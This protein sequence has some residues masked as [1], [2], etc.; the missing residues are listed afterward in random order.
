M[1]RISTAFNRQ[2]KK[3]EDDGIDN[4]DDAGMDRLYFF[5]PRCEPI[6]QG[7][8]QEGQDDSSINQERGDKLKNVEYVGFFAK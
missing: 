4:F 6:F 7:S 2:N 5:A 3:E 8:R 1:T